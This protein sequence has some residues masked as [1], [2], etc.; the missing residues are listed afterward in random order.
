MRPSAH[1]IVTTARRSC[2]APAFT[3]LLLLWLLLASSQ[4]C[5]TI[6]SRESSSCGVVVVVQAFTVLAPAQQ[7]R[8]ASS[9]TTSSRVK[10][11]RS[12]GRWLSSPNSKNQEKKQQQQE[13]E[14]AGA[15]DNVQRTSFDQAGASIIE[16]EDVKRMET[17]GDFDS[18]PNVRS[19]CLCLL[20]VA[21]V[22]CAMYLLFY[23]PFI[24]IS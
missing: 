23:L 9:A 6:M 2:W 22:C 10:N 24:Y 7:S 13:G 21:S 18:N 3:S 19:F 16:E 1:P 15:E 4:Q 8:R 5:T 11:S 14:Q 20:S 17:M 12:T